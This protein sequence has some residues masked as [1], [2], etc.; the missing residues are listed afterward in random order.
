MMNELILIIIFFLILLLHRTLLR[1]CLT[2]KHSAWSSYLYVIV[3][4]I[5][6]LP[7]GLFLK[8]GWIER[9]GLEKTVLFVVLNG[10]IFFYLAWK[11]AG[12]LSKIQDR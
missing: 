10:I 4:I 2:Y 9:F 7:F 11:L 12:G 1:L 8:D 6:Y 3:S 5:L